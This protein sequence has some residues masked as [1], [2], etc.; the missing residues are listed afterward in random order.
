MPQTRMFRIG[1]GIIVILLIILLANQ[2]SFIFNPLVVFV[3]TLFFP[4]LVSGVLFYLFRPVVKA[5]QKLGIPKVIAILLIYL[6]FIGLFV[7]LGFL[8]GPLLKEQFNRL[9]ENFPDMIEKARAKFE[10]LNR[11]PWVAQYVNWN[12]IAAYVTN[13]LESSL[14][15][16]GT[17][18]VN[19]VGVITNII[20]VFVTVP[21][22]LYYM[23]KEG[24]KAPA[25]ML[26]LLP[27][28]ERQQGLKILSDMD[29]ALSS[30]IKGQVLVGIF[31]GLIVYIG[32]LII[33]IDYSLILALLTMFTNVIP[34]VGPLIGIIPALVVAFIDSPIMVVYVLIVA[35][36]AQQLEGNLV[37]PYIMGKNL[38][39]HPLTIILLLL[40]AG[41]LGGFLGLLLAVPTYAV[42][43]VVV[44]HTYRLI[45]LRTEKDHQV[46]L[47]SE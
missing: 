44:S 4:F 37:S 12:E 33:G 38:N 15:Q 29:L 43:K 34:F 8:I 3:Q 5:L 2:V 46:T 10:N 39:I 47:D 31:V 40:V 16:I 6:I 24:E 21:F 22:I 36:V 30:Y 26:R 1:Y 11:Q 42:L 35:V 13:Y 41:S 20:V 9:V 27:E 18:I 25:Y 32:Y 19:F 23:L 28:K 17:N 14:S 7:L 45:K